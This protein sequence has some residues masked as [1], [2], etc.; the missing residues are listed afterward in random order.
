MYAV[1]MIIYFVTLVLFFYWSGVKVIFSALSR[2]YQIFVILFTYLLI[3]GQVNKSPFV[4]YPFT[5][6][7]MYSQAI[8]SPNY[9]EFLI[10]L[11]NGTIEHYPFELIAFT[12]QRA[13]MRKVESIESNTRQKN[14]RDFLDATVNSLVEIYERKYPD[15]K[16]KRFIINEVTITLADGEKGYRSAKVKRFEKIRAK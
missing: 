6:W 14:N 3:V 11:N 10:E 5:Y 13:F 1:E 7:G 9:S 8:P 2:G 12:S 15:M 4:T 16:V